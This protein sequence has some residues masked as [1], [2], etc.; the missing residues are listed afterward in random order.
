MQP[1]T[2][3]LPTVVSDRIVWGINKSEAS[4]A[5]ALDMFKDFGRV[6]HIDLL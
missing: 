3:D 2:A 6:C 5:L 4:R 1:S